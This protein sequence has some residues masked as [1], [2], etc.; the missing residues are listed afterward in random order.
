VT[1]DDAGL[2]VRGSQGAL[3]AYVGALVRSGIAPRAL[4]LDEAP[5]ESLFFLLTESTPDSPPSA[6]SDSGAAR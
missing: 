1:R 3:D 6:L 5:L 2:A 4:S